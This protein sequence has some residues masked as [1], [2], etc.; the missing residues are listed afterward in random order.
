METNHN[1]GIPVIDVN[2]LVLA[3]EARHDVAAKIG[4]A[5]R[6]YGFFYIV[7]HGVD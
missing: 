5:C 4:E 2:P 3:T 6:E 1:S 7:G